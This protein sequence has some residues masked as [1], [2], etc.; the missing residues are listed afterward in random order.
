MCKSKLKYERRKPEQTLLYQTIAGH[1]ET[2]KAEREME[3]RSMPKYLVGEFEGFLRCSIVNATS[4]V[5]RICN[6]ARVPR[7][8]AH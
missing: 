8:T 1:W 4:E 5:I 2:S 7:G 3:G 6:G